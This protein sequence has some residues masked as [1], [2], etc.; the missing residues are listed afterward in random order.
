MDCHLLV[1]AGGVH[2]GMS[3]VINA[4]VDGVQ[5]DF[6]RLDHASTIDWI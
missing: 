3:F 1:N 5:H 4:G 2:A 6:F